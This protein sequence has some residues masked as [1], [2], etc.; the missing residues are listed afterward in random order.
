MRTMDLI[1]AQIVED[2]GIK[3]FIDTHLERVIEK[4]ECS[5]EAESTSFI[6]GLM[7]IGSD[8]SH[9]KSAMGKYKMGVKSPVVNLSSYVTQYIRDKASQTI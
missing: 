5:N 2:F 1:P 6:C 4:L 9:W 3:E 8:T 7:Q